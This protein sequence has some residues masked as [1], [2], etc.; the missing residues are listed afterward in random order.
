MSPGAPAASRGSTALFAAPFRRSFR[1]TIKKRR[2]RGQLALAF[3]RDAQRLAGCYTPLDVVAVSLSEAIAPICGATMA[4]RIIRER[5][6]VW[7]RGHIERNPCAE[8]GKLYAGSRAEKLWT[9]DYVA[10]FLA[11]APRLLRLPMLLAIDPGQRQGDLRMTWSAYD[12]EVIRGRRQ[13]DRQA[14]RPTKKRRGD[15][16]RD[17]KLPTALPTAHKSTG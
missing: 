17:E 2:Q 14:E 8:G 7:T 3:D 6:Y 12:G 16:I 4:A 9:D 15:Q 11:V 13:R 5:W 10:R 1:P